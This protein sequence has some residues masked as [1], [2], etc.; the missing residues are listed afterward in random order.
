MKSITGLKNIFTELIVFFLLIGGH[1]LFAQENL[2]LKKI[3]VVF[4]G[5][6]IPS[7]YARGHGRQ[8]AEL[9]G[10]FHTEVTIRA[11]NDYKSGEVNNFDFTFFVGFSK[12]YNP[13]DKFLKDI[14]A[15]SKTVVDMNTGLEYFSKNYDLKKK[16]GFTFVDFDTLSNFYL[17]K[18]KDKTLPKGEPN[19]NIIKI[20]NPSLCHVVATAVSERQRE[21]PYIISANNF[22]YIADFPLSYATENDRYLLFAD[23]LHDLLGE[24]HAPSHTALIRIEDVDPLEDPVKLREIADYLYSQQIPF[25]VAIIPFYV[26]PAAGLRVS[27]SEKPEFVDA[28]HYM[29]EHGGTVVMHGVT[30]QYREQTAT[31]FEFWDASINKPIKNDSREYVEKKLTAGIEECLKNGI[32]PLLW[33]TPHYAASNLDYSVISKFFSSAIEQ[34]LSMEDLDYSQYFPYV[35]EK[36]LYGQ[37]IYPENLGFVPMDESAEKETEYVKKLIEYARANLIVRDGYAS[38]FFHPFVKLEFLEQLVTGI[39]ELGYTYAD[40]RNDAHI[41]QLKNKAIVSGHGTVTLEFQDQYLRESYLNELGQI[42]RREKSVERLNGKFERGITLSPEWIYIAEP[43]EY[44]ERELSFWQNVRLTLD[45]MVE[46]VFASEKEREELRP[47]ILWNPKARGSSRNDQTSFVAAFHSLNVPVDTILVKSPFKLS[48]G[49][50]LIV[51]YSVVDSLRDEDYGKIRTFVESGGFLIV[52]SKNDLAE[53]LGIKFTKSLLKIEKLR[54]KLYPEEILSWNKPESMHKFDVESGDE[55]LCIDDKTD[56][57]VVIGRKLGKGKFIFFGTRFDP[58]S[59]GG[60]SRF[61][62]LIEYVRKYFNLSPIVRRDFLEVYFDPSFHHLLSIEQL[63]KNWR[64]DGIRLIHIGVHDWTDG[65]KTWVY[66]YDRLIRL[67][68]A[69]GIL[70]YA[71]LEPP[72]VSQKFWFEHP[73]WREK[74]FKGEDI[75]PSWRFPIAL[76]DSLALRA[77]LAQMQDFLVQYDWDGVNLAE[78]YFESGRGPLDPNLLTPMHLSARMEFRKRYS[79]DPGELLDSSSAHYWKT[80]EEDWKK[81]EEYRVNTIVSFHERFLALFQ[82]IQTAKPSFDVIVTAM[83]NLGSPELRRDHGID[84]RRIIELKKKYQFALQIEDPQTLWSKDPRRYF[85]IGKRYEK[86]LGSSSDLMLDLNILAFRKPDK[87]YPFPTLV[88]SGLESYHLVHSAA[89]V[90]D[91]LTIYAESSVNPQDLKMFPYALAAK[92]RVVRVEHGWDIETPY[93]VTL[94]LS[95]HRKEILVDGERHFATTDGTFFIPAGQH[96]VRLVE[97]SVNPFETNLLETRILSVTAN[98]LNQKNFNRG[99][100]FTYSSGQ[101]CLV[102]FNREPFALLLDGQEYPFKAL[103]GDDVF[104]V[105]LPPGEHKVLVITQSQVSY[106]IDVT[107]LWSSSLIVLFGMLSGSVLV[108]FYII[109]RLKR[110][111]SQ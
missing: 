91:R 43:T 56:A 28:I 62:Y 102:T 73:E 111:K 24:P 103:T 3:L 97:S 49:N 17:V 4:E 57:P 39:Q 40:L 31:D 78:L 10:H 1:N 99:V 12:K 7:N 59:D 69:N 90:S 50:L 45:R 53:E 19:C 15:T 88:Q 36:D 76:T 84:V 34:R 44:K 51:P 68:R 72:Q 104:A 30:H 60:Y 67:C 85:D 2:P 63:V 23:M 9:L 82:T 110:K 83:D 66:D 86:I 27:L 87:L 42:A 71:W 16:F 75:R 22:W 108:I 13:P 8:I 55:V 32:Y 29:M 109:V 37:K 93:P 33:E 95:K 107:S 70:V 52:D 96:S 6:D 77:T 46:K 81:F 98:L 74:N 38:A 25:L 105:Q 20:T 26:D 65:K 47:A 89:L 79:F 35:I 48:R 14:Y 58:L 5:S 61:P 64:N 80:H 18:F 101:R 100:E 11:A 54:D 92:A 94:E 21:V 106:G 41:V